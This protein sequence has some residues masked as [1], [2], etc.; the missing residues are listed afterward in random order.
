MAEPLSLAELKQRADIVRDDIDAVLESLITA[1]REW[2][3][4]YTGLTI[5][6]DSVTQ[7][8]DRFCSF[9]SLLVSPG[10]NQ[11]VTVDYVSADDVPTQ[12]TDARVLSATRPARLIAPAGAAW[13]DA[14]TYVSVTVPVVPDTFKAAITL[15]VR[16]MHEDGSISP[17]Y[18]SALEALCFPYRLAL[19]G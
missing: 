17:A 11:S 19:I 8:F 16:A 13:P 18:Q 3:E 12:I 9:M 10:D 6:A 2:V 4:S 7:R 15:Y 14:A 1:G 5:N